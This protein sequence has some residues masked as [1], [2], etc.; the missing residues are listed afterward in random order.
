M[1]FCRVGA[2]S[3]QEMPHSVA[4]QACP[5]VT[6]AVWG[7]RQCVCVSVSAVTRGT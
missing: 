2:I 1:F 3:V 7:M 5:T 6:T 4:K